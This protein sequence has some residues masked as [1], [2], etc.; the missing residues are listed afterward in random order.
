MSILRAAKT[1]DIKPSTAK[2][3]YKCFRDEGRVMKKTKKWK[4]TQRKR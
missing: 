4:K 1:L 2:Y 3:I